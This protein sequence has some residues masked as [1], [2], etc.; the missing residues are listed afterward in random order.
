MK[1]LRCCHGDD[2][3]QIP[4][5]RD[6]AIV[7]TVR[8]RGVAAP[9]KRDPDW[10]RFFCTRGEGARVKASIAGGDSRSLCYA[11]CVSVVSY[12]LHLRVPRTSVNFSY[13]LKP[14]AVHLPSYF[15]YGYSL[16]HFI[17][18]SYHRKYLALFFPFF[19]FLHLLL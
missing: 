17:I 7:R 10:A 2:R 12:T 11:T 8:M 15:I 5:T 4:W 14:R 6:D 13:S 9:K 3:Y 19:L 18:H 16:I 1:E